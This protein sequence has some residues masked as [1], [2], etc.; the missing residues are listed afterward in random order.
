ML[1]EKTDIDFPLFQSQIRDL[2]GDPTGSPFPETY[3][4][5]M[6]FSEFAPHFDHVTN[7]MG[8]PWNY[9]I[10]GNYILEDP[11]RRAFGL[12]VERGLARELQ[13]FD[14]CFNIRRMKGGSG[15]SVHS[16]GLAVDFNAADNPYGGQIS[17]SDEFIRCFADAG[18]ESGALWRT[19][20]AMH[21]QTPWTEIRFGPLA[22]VAW[23]A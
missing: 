3:L 8:E 22:P 12:L 9:K 20:D 1:D 10:Y 23:V 11:L 18:F 2:F 6:N 17:F 21:F 14:G 4:R 15:Y 5:T 16:W 7:C 13:T 19:K